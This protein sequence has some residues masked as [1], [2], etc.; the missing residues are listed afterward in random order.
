MHVHEW[1]VVA[2]FD[3]GYVLGRCGRCDEQE[4]LDV[5]ALVPGPR[6]AATTREDVPADAATSA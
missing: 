2:E 6:A 1:N 5:G 3:A 4:L